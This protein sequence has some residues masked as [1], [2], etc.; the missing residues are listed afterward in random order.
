KVFLPLQQF[1]LCET[2]IIGGQDAE[3]HSRPYMAFLEIRGEENIRCGGFLLRDNVVLTAAHCNEGCLGSVL[4]ITV[5]LGAH[6]ITQTEKTQQRVAVRRK[7]PHPD[8]KRVPLGKG[9][10]LPINDLMLLQLK[11][12]VTRKHSVRPIPLPSLGPTVKPGSMCS[13]AGWGSVSRHP[14]DLADTLQEVDLKVIS[15]KSCSR[16][17]DMNYYYYSHGSPSPHLLA[18]ILQGDSG[19]PLVCNGTVQGIVSCGRPNGS[20]PR[21]FTRITKFLPWI[22]KTLRNALRQGSISN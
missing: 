18:L 22:K 1:L 21:I 8:F 2:M 19:G 4:Q 14:E 10:E 6:D 13:A 15:V 3:P 17:L 20:P 5:V 7:V 9:I 11:R 12:P 16:K